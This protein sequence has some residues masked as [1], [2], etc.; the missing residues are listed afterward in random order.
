MKCPK[1]GFESPPNFKF[2]GECG[3]KLK[4]ICSECGFDNPPNFKFCGECG[5]KLGG[6]V[7]ERK[8]L[9][10]GTKSP[11][12]ETKDEFLGQGISESRSGAEIHGKSM[13]TE[14]SE[15]NMGARTE[16]GARTGAKESTGLR[17]V[18]KLGESIEM[19]MEIAKEKLAGHAVG[20]DKEE[21]G[22]FESKPESYEFVRISDKPHEREHERRRSGGGVSR[23]HEDEL[24]MRL[25]QVSEQDQQI[26]KDVGR[27]ERIAE[28]RVREE[29]GWVG[30]KIG[31]I[32]YDA[33]VAIEGE[34]RPISV[35]FADVSGFTSLSERL[36][37]EELRDLMKDILGKLASIIIKNGGTIDKFIGDE[38]MALFGAPRAFGDD[39]KRAVQT[40]LDILEFMKANYPDGSISVHGGISTG[41]AVV[42]SI[43]K[44]E[45]DYTAMGDTVNIGKRLEEESES[46]HFLV[47]ENTYLITSDLFEYR[48]VDVKLKGKSKYIRVFE[49][50]GR[51]K[52]SERFV[53][54]EKELRYVREALKKQSRIA[55]FGEAGVGVSSF[56]EFLAENLSGVIK[57]PAGSKEEPYS[58]IK[59]IILPE[60]SYE[61]R[62]I[63]ISERYNVSFHFLG[64]IFGLIFPNSPLKYMPPDEIEFEVMKTIAKV[65]SGMFPSKVL[66]V[67]NFENT[68]IRTQQFFFGIGKKYDVDFSIILGFDKG[69]INLSQ[70]DGWEFVELKNFGIEETR[71]FLRKFLG[72]DVEEKTLNLIWERTGGNP[73]FISEFVLMLR[74]KGAFVL[75]GGLVRLKDGIALPSAIGIRQLILSK[76][77][78]LPEIPRYV[79]SVI[80]CLDTPHIDVLRLFF[81]EE[82]IDLDS[83][84]RTLKEHGFIDVDGRII[85]FKRRV[86]KDVAYDILLKSRR[87][88]IHSALFDCARRICDDDIQLILI[89]ASQ[90]EKAMMN[91]EAFLM[92]KRAGALCASRFNMKEAKTYFQKALS[93]SVD[94]MLRSEVYECCIDFGKVLYHIGEIDN[95]LEVF[96]KSLKYATGSSEEIKAKI[97]IA[98]C[99]QVRGDFDGAEKIYMEIVDKF[100]LHDTFRPDVAK[101]LALLCHLYVDRGKPHD[102][103]KYGEK[104]LSL[105]D[106]NMKEVHT[107]IYAD[108]INALGRC[109][110]AMKEYEKAKNF[111]MKFYEISMK[112]DNMKMRGT[113]LANYAATLFALGELD[114][115]L[116]FCREYL[117]ISKSI[118]NVRG[119]AI[120]LANI[121]QMLFE[122][123]KI[124]KAI[125][126]ITESISIFEKIGD[127]YGYRETMEMLAFMK[128]SIGEYEYARSIIDKIM[129]DTDSPYKR[130]RYKL[131]LA[132]SYIGEGNFHIAEKLL[133]EAILESKE[134][135]SEPEYKI[136]LS[137]ILL[138]KG[139]AQLAKKVAEESLSLSTR[140]T[141]RIFSLLNIIKIMSEIEF[142]YIMYKEE[143]ERYRA[144]LE[145][146]TNRFPEL[147][148]NMFKLYL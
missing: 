19:K 81:E 128:V 83:S 27:V 25:Q 98:D 101:A 148:T 29:G 38:V 55:I 52:G 117:E 65:L 79:L 125:E 135:E 137:K 34:R 11:K 84:L 145:K 16:V 7:G 9:D 54:R 120:A 73:L 139:E 144:E 108:I 62:I 63:D 141:Q 70:L 138:S 51:K 80:A 1:C 94:D 10:A 96:S 40:A 3:E 35:L 5:A 48:P 56:I 72:E 43:Y 67:D 110:F 105:F 14:V 119:Q 32:G 26:K 130:A 100:S 6:V 33:D 142:D 30:S 75:E 127:N 21:K 57:A 131:I 87:Q 4:N 74:E 61:R 64:Y 8:S 68:D 136:A 28:E 147:K 134:I 106:G 90:A 53:G 18:E 49:L 41:E 77:D 23:T 85:V 111:F 42:G 91:K 37:P 71:D 114:T 103:I 22:E 24:V 50:V 97:W 123:G 107:D 36:D 86:F 44:R 46:G 121:S 95:A 31:G 99:L 15:A 109:Y 78:R 132:L 112:I 143:I 58:T 17:G 93:L 133:D 89:S 122:S 59:K 88:K 76:I 115:A 104:A 92:Y 116:V 69:S 13:L 12:V 2:C 113:A 20:E 124:T 126:N 39:T 45:G 129:P 66:I 140:D 60:G 47:D 82:K 102:G 146:I 118:M